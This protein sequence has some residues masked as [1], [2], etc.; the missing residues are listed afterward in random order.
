MI[1]IL[2]MLAVAFLASRYAAAVVPSANG[3]VRAIVYDSGTNTL[4][5]GGDFTTFGG[6]TR[7]RL[8][9][10]NVSTGAVTAWDPDVDGLV[11][12]LAISGSTVYAGGSFKTVNG[13]TK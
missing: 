1:P 13:G 2:V 3:E 6:E 7:N 9:A 12:V 4:F 5:V 10:F 11:R 8:A